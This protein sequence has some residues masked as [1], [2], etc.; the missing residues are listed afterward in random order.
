MYEGFEY[1]QIVMYWLVTRIL[2]GCYVFGGM[3]GSEL[4]KPPSTA[5]A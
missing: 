4:D 2:K 5:S 1:A 3:I